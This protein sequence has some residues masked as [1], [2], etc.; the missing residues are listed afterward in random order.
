MVDQVEGRIA[1]Q[2]DVGVEERQIVNLARGR[3]VI[4]FAP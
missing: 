1:D 2:L 3:A 4:T